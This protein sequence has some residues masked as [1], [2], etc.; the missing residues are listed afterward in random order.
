M[1]QGS[2][3]GP[4]LFNLFLNDLLILFTANSNRSIYADENIL[5]ASS[6][7]LEE[8]KHILHCDLKKLKLFY[9]NYL[10]LNQSKCYFMCLERNTEN[11]TFVFASK[12]MK[13][14]EEQKTLGI[15]IDNRL[16]SKSRAKNIFK[17]SLAKRIG[18]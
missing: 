9:E 12:I 18:P 17:K 10:V 15:I 8:I 2:I 16:N 7:K 6:Q 4:L 14:S 13:N 11:K 3:L 5:Y 1:P